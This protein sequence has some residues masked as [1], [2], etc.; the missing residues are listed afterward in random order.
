MGAHILQCYSCL[1]TGSYA[2]FG[3]PN[4]CPECASES[5]HLAD[6]GGDAWRCVQC[7][8]HMRDCL[9]CERCHLTDAY[10]ECM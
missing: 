4:R 10:C 6:A 8:D 3:V 1:V 2:R 9:C 7:G 5:V